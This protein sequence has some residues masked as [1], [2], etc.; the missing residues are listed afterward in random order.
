MSPLASLAVVA[1]LVAVAPARAADPIADEA[2]LYLDEQGEEVFGPLYL[3]TSPPDIGA[4]QR[5]GQ[6]AAGFRLSARAQ[7]WLDALRPAAA[8]AELR[9]RLP[10]AAAGLERWRAR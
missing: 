4:R 3:P 8:F 1:A 10:D 9:E 2:P 5:A 7:R 6:P